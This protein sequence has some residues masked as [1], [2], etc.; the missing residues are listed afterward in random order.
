[1]EHLIVCLKISIGLGVRFLEILYIWEAGSSI[2]V[3]SDS[4]LRKSRNAIQSGISSG[5]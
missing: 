3:G 1:M 4:E 5:T 2:S